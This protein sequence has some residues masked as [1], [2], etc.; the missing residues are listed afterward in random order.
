MGAAHVDNL[1]RWV[2]GRAV[3]RRSSTSTPSARSPSPT[4]SGASGR[5]VGRGADRVRR[6]RRG[7]DRRPRPAAR[8]AHAR[9]HRARQAHPAGEADR[10]H[11]RGRPPRRRRRGR[12]RPPAGPARVHAALRPGVPP[13]ARGRARRL[14]RPGQGGPLHPPQPARHPSHTDES[15]LFGSMIHEFDSVPWLLDDPLAAVTVFASRVAEGELKDLQV[16]V[17]ETAGGS[18]VTVE[19]FI[20]AQLRLRHPHRGHRHRGHGLADR[21]RTACPCGAASRTPPA[22]T[23][24]W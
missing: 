22:S 19:V 15:V 23:A 24:G 16:A 8:A 13:A 7:P 3:S 5:P 4:G 21:R 11:A 1:A 12:G 18:V 17:F 14:D 2:P 20:N 10:E 6:R 9:L